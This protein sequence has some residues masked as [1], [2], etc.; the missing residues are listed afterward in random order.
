MAN[1]RAIRAAWTRNVRFVATLTIRTGGIGVYYNKQ[2]N[3]LTNSTKPQNDLFLV[4]LHVE[5]LELHISNNKETTNL[6]AGL[7]ISNHTEIITQLLLLE[8][9]LGKVLAN[10]FRY[11]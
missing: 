1:S 8:V 4:L 2:T 7:S 11:Y 5:I 6:V 9:L 10:N 3:E